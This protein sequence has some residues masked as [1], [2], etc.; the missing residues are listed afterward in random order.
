MRRMRGGDLDLLALDPHRV[1][2]LLQEAAER[3]IGLIADQQHGAVA[4]AQPALEMMADAAGVAHAAGG[5]DDVKAVEPRDRL[6]L[7]DGLGEAQ[8]RRIAA[9]ARRRCRRRDRRRACE[10]LRWRGS[11]AA[12]PER[13]AP[14]APRRAPSARSDRRSVPGCARPRRP[15]SAAR[16]ARRS[17]V[18]HLGR[19]P[20]AALL[21]RGR[22]A[23][24]RVAIGGFADHIVEVVRRFRIG[25]QQFGVGADD[26]RRRAAA[27]ARRPC[28][29]RRIRSRSR[30]S[31]ADGRRS[32]SA[33]ARRG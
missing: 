10:T 12:N 26:R 11:P 2:A 28:L 32:S 5:D 33:R 1:G 21:R 16:P 14:S 27:A 15:G 7:V 23:R 4:P 20:C 17:G 22:P 9:A 30:P 25:L 19:E 13:S 6:A 18:A 29:R 31:R 24:S 8:M 3:A